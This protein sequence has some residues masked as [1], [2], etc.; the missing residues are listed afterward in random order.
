M[1]EFLAIPV[2]TRFSFAFD[3]CFFLCRYVHSVANQ[4][5]SV[6]SIESLPLNRADA[7][8]SH[9]FGGPPAGSAFVFQATAYF[10]TR[11]A[12]KLA[13]RPGLGIPLRNGEDEYGTRMSLRFWKKIMSVPFV[14]ITSAPALFA[15]ASELIRAAT[16]SLEARNRSTLRPYCFSNASST[17]F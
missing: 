14:S 11:S 6:G 16:V 1:T 15:S 10:S 17:G 4:S 8:S 13:Y 12:V 3:Q 7:R 9:D 2:N 5:W